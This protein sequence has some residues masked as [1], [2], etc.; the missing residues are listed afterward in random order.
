MRDYPQEEQTRE[1]ER[2]HGPLDCI[3]DNNSFG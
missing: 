3:R 1:G 2:R